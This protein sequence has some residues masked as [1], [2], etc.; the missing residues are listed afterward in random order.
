MV[1]AYLILSLEVYFRISGGGLVQG[2]AALSTRRSV[3]G[4]DSTHAYASG[5][6]GLFIA[7]PSEQFLNAPIRTH[8]DT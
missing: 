4:W 2:E 8:E 7:A 5:C 1:C 6:V 3:R